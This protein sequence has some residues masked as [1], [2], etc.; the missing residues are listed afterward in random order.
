MTSK[1]N[2]S[3]VHHFVPRSVLRRF[4]ANADRNFVMVFDKVS[5]RTWEGGLTSTASGK[6]Y[7]TFVQPDG[8]R[9]NFERDFDQTDKDYATIFDDLDSLRSL[10][11]CDDVFL[12]RL[13]DVVA[14]QLLRT[15]LVR[16][17]LHAV[18]HEF[19]LEM[20]SKGVVSI[21]SDELPD[22]NMVRQMTRDLIAERTSNRDALLAKDIILF[23]PI[24]AARF[25]TSDHP[26]VRHS[27][28]PLGELGL[29]SLGV[30]IYLPVSS[31][32]LLG[33]LCPSLRRGSNSGEGGGATSAVITEDVIR[34][35]KPLRI[36]DSVVNFFNAL[37]VESAQRFL[38][39]SSDGF[40]LAHKMLTLR[41]ELSSNDTLIH[42]GEMGRAPPRPSNMPKG[43]WLYLETGKG[44]LMIPICDFEAEGERERC[45]AGEWI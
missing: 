38:Y 30:E 1:Q 2:E 7:N 12:N 8:E 22:D 11:G 41:P 31:D 16:S 34:A 18:S 24:G 21:E 17:T 37:Q 27:E 9:I 28:L 23:E 20:A 3:N 36:A 25:W 43:E 45:R 40:E 10:A 4:A 14:V 6:G 19:A 5:G 13:A 15:P 26:V 35:G 42:M 32:L 39:A 33:F 44:Y 29:Q